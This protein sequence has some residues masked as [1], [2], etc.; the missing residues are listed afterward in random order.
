MSFLRWSFLAN[1]LSLRRTLFIFLFLGIALIHGKM[2]AQKVNQKPPSK[3]HS[4][5]LKTEFIQLKD[6]FNYGLVFNGLNLGIDYSFTKS[7]GNGL[8]E[9]GAGLGFGANYNKGIGLSWRLKPIDIFYGRKI[10]AKNIYPGAYFASNYQW[11]LYPELQ[12]GHMFW[13]TAIEIGPQI[14]VELP[15]KARTIKVTFSNSIAGLN[16]RPVPATELY[17]YSLQVADFF[18]NGHQNLKFGT[19]NRFNHTRLKI[20]LVKKAHKRLGFAYIFEY[21]GYYQNPKINIMN[22][23]LQLKWKIGKK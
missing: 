10:N 8:L 18:S 20:E 15:Y 12:S 17:Y 11:Q 5:S 14:V 19:Y 1:G 13:F 2:V 23:A 21:F 16:S 9:Y 3:R 6:Q 4:I 7:F 22:H